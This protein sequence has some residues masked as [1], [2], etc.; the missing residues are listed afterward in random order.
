VSADFHDHPVAQLLAGVIEQH[1]RQRVEVIAASLLP[2]AGDLGKRITASADILVDATHLTDQDTAMALR[3]LGV[4]IAIDLQGYTQGQRPGIFRHR[5]APVQVNYL[6][7]AGTMGSA[8]HDYIVADAMTIP[9]GSEGDFSEHVLRLPHSFLPIDDRQPVAQ[10]TGGREA[11]GLPGAGFVFC[12][13]SNHYK[14]LP[15]TFDL[16]TR[17][18]KAVPGSC[19][20]LRSGISL[21]NDRLREAAFSR[22]VDPARLVFASR[23]PDLADHL[24]RF[25][26]A[27]L[28]LDTWPCNA[29]ATAANALWAGLPVLTLAGAAFAGRVGASLLHAAG[30]PDLV[31]PSVAEYEALALRL[32]CD[33]GEMTSIRERLRLAKASAPLFNTQRYCRDLEAGLAQV[34]DRHASGLAPSHLA[35]PSRH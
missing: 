28:F 10:D 30:L 20:W 34:W 35:V 15:P 22:G 8:C 17:L 3:A 5:A 29:H 27:D 31:A 26:L 33:P 16:W 11:A 14:I 25:R 6:G 18:L 9:V 21:V 7:Y 1:D 12:A 23:V 13:F 19:L 32:A 2:P 4:D 24:G